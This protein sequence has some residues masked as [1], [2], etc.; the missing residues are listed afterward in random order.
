M[1]L[2]DVKQSLKDLEKIKQEYDFSIEVPEYG[3]KEIGYDIRAV[4]ELIKAS[5][6]TLLALKEWEKKGERK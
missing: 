2:K 4:E 6:E 3:E 5:E 1:R